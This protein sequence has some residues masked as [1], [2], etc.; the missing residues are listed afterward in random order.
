MDRR[1]FNAL[2]LGAASSASLSAYAGNKA[3]TRLHLYGAAGIRLTRYDVDAETADLAERETIDLPSPIQYAWLHPSNRALYVATSDAANGSRT[4]NGSVHRVCAF[5]IAADGRL[6]P[7]G[8]NQALPQR[9]IHI[10]VDASGRFLLAA[11]NTIPDVAVHPILPGLGVGPRIEQR[12]PLDLG[13]FP[14]QV[15]MLP[16]G[17]STVLVTRGI[18][19][20]G[21]TPEQPGA[22]KLYRFDEGRLA[23]LASVAVGGRG[24]LGYGP[25]H[26][27]FHPK[28]PWAYVAIER[29]NELH[30]H[31]I[32]DDGFVARPDFIRST[33]AVVPGTRQVA[34]AIHVHPH[35]IAVYVSNRASE[36]VDYEGRQVAKGG[37]NSIAVFR[38][39]PTTGEP[40]LAQRIDPRGYHV[41]SFTIAP[42]GKLLV[43]ADMLDMLVREGGGIRRVSAGLSLFR[44]D[45]RGLLEFVRKVDVALPDHGQEVWVK[46]VALPA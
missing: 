19:A 26:L 20:R 35:G 13:I 25:R 11:F 5:A 38:I 7:I 27:D 3:R 22:L 10:S 29:Q 8:E 1:Y 33:A 40:L 21:D 42:D 15:R 6:S 32:V 9:P 44:I 16:G 14:H 46:L 36:T 43:A 34:G 18:D 37:D 2:M 12:E 23:P 31:R 30:M 39:D 17:R 45:G 24:G 4:I 41:R 28:R